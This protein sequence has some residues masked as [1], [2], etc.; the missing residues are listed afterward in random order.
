MRFFLDKLQIQAPNILQDDTIRDVALKLTHGA[1]GV[2][3]YACRTTNETDAVSVWQKYQRP[4]T[5]SEMTAELRN[6][7]AHQ[8][9][10]MLAPYEFEDLAELFP[11]KCQW[12]YVP[13]GQHL[14]HGVRVKPP[15]HGYQL[16]EYTNVKGTA[17]PE[18]RLYDYVGVTDVFAVT[19]RHLFQVYLPHAAGMV[20]DDAVLHSAV[21]RWSWNQVPVYRWSPKIPTRVDLATLFQ[22]VHANAHVPCIQYGKHVRVYMRQRLKE[23]QNKK[24][25]LTFYFVLG[26]SVTFYENGSVQTAYVQEPLRVHPLVHYVNQVL[27]WKTAIE[28]DALLMGTCVEVP[29]T[30]LN[31]SVFPLCARNEQRRVTMSAECSVVLDTVP[32]AWSKVFQDISYLRCSPHGELS[33]D[34]VH[35]T[36]SNLPYEA[37]AFATRYTEGMLT[38]VEREE[39]CTLEEETEFEMPKESMTELDAF[40]NDFLRA[41]Y[42]VGGRFVG[43]VVARDCE[44]VLG[45]L[46]FQGDAEDAGILPSWIRPWEPTL[47]YVE[48]KAYLQRAAMIRKEVAP[49]ERV[50]DF[51]AKCVG[52]GTASGAFA[53]CHG[54]DEDELRV[55][56]E[57]ERLFPKVERMYGVF[58]E[59]C[60]TMGIHTPK[61]PLEGRVVFV[62]HFKSKLPEWI[63]GKWLV[64]RTVYEEYAERLQIELKRFHRVRSYV[65][66]LEQ[67]VDGVVHDLLE[68]ERIEG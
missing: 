30:L 34:G 27:T 59:A 53:P 35:V 46:P 39:D 2:Y 40:V 26:G 14:K 63:D 13:L 68:G 38:H 1:G 10:N 58:R 62:D 24:K 49:V 17:Q 36:L 67:S 61:D 56:T 21:S 64:P 50:Y 45:F 12:E 15:K 32:A 55:T 23:K 7:G 66:R 18:K 9:L 60:R 51:R 5:C 43:G 8:K 19:V 11:S 37:T 20:P 44:N 52:L 25:G 65:L 28:S 42:D 33:T 48:L 47:T 29:A 57:H 41:G 16:D 3:L 22:R 4:L 31:Q 54:V 6:V